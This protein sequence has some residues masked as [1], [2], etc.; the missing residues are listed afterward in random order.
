MS[1]LGNH[2]SSIISREILTHQTYGT[3]SDLWSLGVVFFILLTQQSPFEGYDPGNGAWQCVVPAYVPDHAKDLVSQL[4]QI[5]TSHRIS[6]KK[7]LKHPF[8]TGTVLL[9]GPVQCAGP[10]N[11][12]RLKPVSLVTKWGSIK[13][14]DLGNVILESPRA[15]YNISA[16]GLSVR[17]LW[18]KVTKS[19]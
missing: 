6:L 7:A 16:D 5:D 10:L 8:I 4:L 14:D 18:S 13:I 17:L 19:I 11:T 12:T 1:A 9:H 2:Y 3:E 15:V